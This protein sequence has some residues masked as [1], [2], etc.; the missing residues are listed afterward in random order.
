L[1]VSETVYAI[2]GDLVASRGYDDRVESHEALENALNVTNRLGGWER[3]LLITVGDE[4]QGIYRDLGSALQAT[5]MV[6][7][8]LPGAFDCRFGI[9][10]G[11]YT[12]IDRDNH[13]TT[14]DGSAWWNARAAINRA[15]ELSHRR[16]RKLAGLRTW[17][18]D[19]PGSQNLLTSMTNA[20]LACRDE[21]VSA[22]SERRRRLLHGRLAG[23]GIE[24][25]ATMEGISSA[26]VSKSLS[27]SGANSILESMAT[28]MNWKDQ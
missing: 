25:L 6:R 2:V 13:S 14:Q 16:V 15:E 17:F 19:T 18:V 22:M 26:A 9:G 23:Q 3:K 7:L 21:I 27:D 8:L 5:L 11:E 1:N 10:A 28:V 12:I 20:H 4:F 24:G